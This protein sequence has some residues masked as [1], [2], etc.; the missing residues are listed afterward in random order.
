MIEP[1]PEPPKSELRQKY[2]AALVAELEAMK[3]TTLTGKGGEQGPLYTAKDRV[4]LLDQIRQYLVDSK[5]GP[6]YGGA[7]GRRAS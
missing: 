3:T 5:T 1:R 6:E 2:E 7:L 4:A